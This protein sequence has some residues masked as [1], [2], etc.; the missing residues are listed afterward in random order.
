MS[1]LD[2]KIALDDWVRASPKLHMVHMAPGCTED[3]RQAGG[4]SVIIWIIFAV[5]LGSLSSR[6]HASTGHG[7]FGSKRGT[8]TILGRWS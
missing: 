4:G 5:K 2:G 7:C 6:V 8:D 1:E 3:R